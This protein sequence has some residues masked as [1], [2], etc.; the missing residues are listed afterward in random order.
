MSAPAVTAAPVVTAAPA[1]YVQHSGR[2]PKR[3][4]A[5]PPF[6]LYSQ[7]MRA[8]LQQEEPDIGYP[9]PISLVPLLSVLF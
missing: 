5:M 7:E 8:K 6:A 2:V 4:G 9:T 1:S 3:P